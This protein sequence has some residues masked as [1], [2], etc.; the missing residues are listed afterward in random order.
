MK[1]A[2]AF[3][4]H[5][6]DEHEALTTSTKDSPASSLATA[7]SSRRG[8]TQLRQELQALRQRI[9]SEQRILDEDE[10]DD[11]KP[12]R[13]ADRWEAIDSAPS[14]DPCACLCCC[15]FPRMGQSYILHDRRVQV[16]GK[17]KRSLVL[18][19]PHWVGV[20]VTFAITVTA[21]G[22]FLHQQCALLPWYYT[23]ITLAFCSMTL[24]YLYQVAFTDPGIVRP[25]P[26]RD[27]KGSIADT[28]DLLNEK[29]G[30]ADDLLDGDDDL[31]AG[32]RLNGFPRSSSSS[33]S[34]LYSPSSRRFCDICGITQSAFTEHCEDCGVCIEEYDHH[35]PWMG[36]CIGKNNMRA[37]KLFNVVWVLYVVFV[38]GV[39]V[40]NVDR[41]HP[42]THPAVHRFQR[43]PD[44]EWVPMTSPGPGN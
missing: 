19:G 42:P 43:N 32:G 30:D 9:D 21:S 28:V 1:M 33:M 13:R 12:W 34:S 6:A 41:V 4:A 31:E 25:E 20:V 23:A 11:A 8:P 27:E 36:K 10:D 16:N 26:T 18:V 7:G 38:L 17:S 2:R 3:E 40:Q 22:M 15:K 39:S 14:I 35:C 37:F 29:E 24:Y 44:G 5:D